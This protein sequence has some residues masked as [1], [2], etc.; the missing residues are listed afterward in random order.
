MRPGKE[1]IPLF[2]REQLELSVDG[3]PPIQSAFH[4]LTVG[5]ISKVSI[6]IRPFP[7][8][9]VEPGTLAFSANGMPLLQVAN[10]APTLLFGLG[11][12]RTLD[13]GDELVSGNGARELSCRLTE[14]FTMDGEIFEL[15]SPASVRISPGPVVRF[16]ASSSSVL[17]KLIPRPLRAR[18]AAS[19]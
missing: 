8:G 4:T 14:G 1:D 17:E 12:Q 3:R 11:D 10:N 5:S 13:F 19:T 16:W 2:R 9:E 15:S 7:P 18:R 6:G